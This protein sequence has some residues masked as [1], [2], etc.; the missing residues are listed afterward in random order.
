MPDG[1]VLP[2]RSLPWSGAATRE[3][4][5]DASFFISS[6]PLFLSTSTEYPS[7]GRAGATPGTCPLSGDIR[8]QRGV[9]LG[10]TSWEPN[11]VGAFE[12]LLIIMSNK[13][14]TRVPGAR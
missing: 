11:E 14:M 1:Q 6:L 4:L 8:W 3:S 2:D 5:H 7:K 12:A 10:K 13:F 9:R